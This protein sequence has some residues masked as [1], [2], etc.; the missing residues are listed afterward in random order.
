MLGRSLKSAKKAG[1]SFERMV[2]DYLAEAL[3]DRGIDR[4]VRTGAKDLGDVRGVTIWGRKIAVECKN[5]LKMALPQW[6]REAEVERGNLD[7]LA[8]V[9]VHKRHGSAKP[10]EQLVTMTLADFAAL[11]SGSRC[12]E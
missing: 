2:A 12:S 3:D 10:G 9:V 1:S 8:G 6:L 11:L 4:Q 5:V 7:G